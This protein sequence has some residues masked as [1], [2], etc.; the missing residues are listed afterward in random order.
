MVEL[1]AE[2]SERLK[3]YIDEFYKD[4]GNVDVYIAE[5]PYIKNLYLESSYS[6]AW[7]VLKLPWIEAKADIFVKEDIE[8]NYLSD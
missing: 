6:D 8:V 7:S 5:K 1:D 4:G 2:D 3:L